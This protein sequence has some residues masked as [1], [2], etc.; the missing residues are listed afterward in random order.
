MLYEY[1]LLSTFREDLPIGLALCIVPFVLGWAFAFFFH[2]VSGLQSQVKQLTDETKRLNDRV[3]H[4]ES[5][6][7][8]TRMKLA[9]AESDAESKGEQ[10]TRTK[11]KLIDAEV[12]LN[13]LKEKMKG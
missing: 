12:E 10:L 13:L 7:T 9:A 2:D 11:S 4:L 6:L 1:I 5:D 8:D 3:E